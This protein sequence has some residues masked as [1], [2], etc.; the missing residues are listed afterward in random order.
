MLNRKL[1]TQLVGSY[2]KPNWLIR[3][4]RVTTPY[5][6]NTFWRPEAAVLLEAQNDATRLAIA[7]QE[8]AGLDVVTDGEERRQRFDSYFFRFDG[9]DTANLAPW[10]MDKRDMSFIDLDSRVG[11]RLAGAQAPR[12]VGKLRWP[13]PIALEDL[14]FLKRHARRPVKMTVIGPLTTACRV[15]NAYYPDE[16][17]LGMDAAGVINEELKAL[18]AEG[19]DLLQLDEP[20]FHFRPDQ[21]CRWGTRALDRA[22]EG[23][24][25]PTIVHICYGYATVGVKHVDPNYGRA[26]EAIAASRAQAISLEY[27]QPGQDPEVLRHCGDKEVLLGLL[28]LGTQTV[29]KPEYIASRIRGALEILPPER[30]H[31]G[32]DC[33]MWFLPREVA[34]R[35]LCAL[36]LGA[37]I[38]RDEIG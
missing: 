11:S 30:L 9:L 1:T 14:R 35:K 10:S 7:D 24:H 34:F 16:E 3:H 5:N 33:G 26:L 32:P 36:V 8:A 25:V 21:V 17:A 37:A 6:D 20:D 13:G 4:H 23:I 2:S 18:Q 15:V 29:E 22:L 31:L 27:E 12:V 28:N 38:V 19:V